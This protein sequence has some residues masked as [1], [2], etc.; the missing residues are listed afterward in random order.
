MQRQVVGLL[1]LLIGIVI[2]LL[3][4]WEVNTAIPGVSIDS[5][6][7]RNNNY[8]NVWNNTNTTSNTIFTL[9]PVIGIIVIAGIMLFYISRF[10]GG[11]V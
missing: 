4:F 6:T 10:G 3:V 8:R 11:G 1:V 9:L 7:D 2:G 5:A